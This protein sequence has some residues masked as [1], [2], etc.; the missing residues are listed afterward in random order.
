M[1]A[2]ELTASLPRTLRLKCVEKIM[3]SSTKRHPS[4]INVC[5]RNRVVIMLS[6]AG[7]WRGAVLC[8]TTPKGWGVCFKSLKRGP[9]KRFYKLSLIHP[10]RSADTSD[11]IREV[12]LNTPLKT[13]LKGGQGNFSVINCWRA[14]SFIRWSGGGCS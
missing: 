10:A 5:A 2:A 8:D 7:K 1:T 9:F 11:T 3:K 13:L 14:E 4:P 12:I 6:L